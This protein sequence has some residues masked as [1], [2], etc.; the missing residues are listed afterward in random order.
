MIVGA[1]SV[2]LCVSAIESMPVGSSARVS[3]TPV[4]ASA[5]FEPA[6]NIVG[7]PRTEPAMLIVPVAFAVTAPPAT[8]PLIAIVW[9]MVP[10]SKIAP[11]VHVVAV[12]LVLAFNTSA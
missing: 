5:I 11:G 12:P 1:I 2:M 8:V 6:D 10:P 3:I 9:P 4:A 7:P